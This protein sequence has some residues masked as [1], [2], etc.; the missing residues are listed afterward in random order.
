MPKELTTQEYFRKL[1][2]IHGAMLTGMI[3]LTLV[4]I[5]ISQVSPIVI[6][7][8]LFRRV[9][10]GLIP[11][12]AIMG[13]YIGARLFKTRLLPLREKQHLKEKLGGYT[14]LLLL[15][16][17]LLEGPAL[18]SIMGFILTG[19]YLFLGITLLLFFIFIMNKPSRDKIEADL[20]LGSHESAILDDPYAIVAEVKE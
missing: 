1:S 6:D 9:L 8:E 13:I 10:L 3:L 14:A 12:V 5:Y 20:A 11:L 19:N 18:F 16:L 7:N 17:A 2:I 15:F 4:G